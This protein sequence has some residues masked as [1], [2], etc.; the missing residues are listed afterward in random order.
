M[1][2]AL[3]WKILIGGIVG[4]LL[5]L[6][7]RFF[8]FEAFVTTQVYVIGEVFLRALMM[9][10]V[11]LIF[12]SIV[13]GIGNIR[14]VERI[15]LL[16]SKTAVYMLGTT[17]VAVLLG[18]GTA[19]F[20]QPGL[21]SEVP[22]SRQL[23][24]F[25]LQV[26]GWRDIFIQIVPKNPIE[27][28]VQSQML[29]VILFSLLFGFFMTKIN[30][31]Q[32]AALRILF[33]GVFEVMMKLTHF[34]VGFAPYGVCAIVAKVV[35]QTG[36]NAVVPLAQ[37]LLAVVLG[38]GV[39]SLIFLPLLLWIGGVHPIRL[40]KAVSSALLMGFSTSSSSATLPVTMDV[41]ERNAGVSNR[42]SSF[43]LPLGTGM[44][45]NG[46]ALYES[47][48]A[49]FIAQVYGIDLSVA[50]QVGVVVLSVLAGIGTAGVP[51]AGLAMLT[52]I[53]QTIGL[54][55]EGIGLVLAVE[56]LLGM[57]RTAVNIWGTSCGAALIARSEKE[58]LT[59]A[60]KSR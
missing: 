14:S 15:G 39:H 35:A 3:H 40:F 24:D 10:I 58:P 29:P 42:I 12:S 6:L 36:L 26:H 54:P 21:G 32:Y 18:L 1:K 55:L 51:M 56:P 27:A 52:V 7:S 13:C 31:T 34:V 4:V 47:L 20:L 37:F 30:E 19:L 28:M 44:N 46:T 48:T 38:L 59:V 16:M 41:V 25:S 45:M 8:G 23:M 60:F 17:T 33:Q 9:I 49:L 57:L 2:L 22:L 43:V 11:P 50:Q 53:L 5:G